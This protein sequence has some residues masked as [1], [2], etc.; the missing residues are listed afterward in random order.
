MSSGNNTYRYDV[1]LS[2][3]GEDR[4]YV[5][6]L[7]DSLRSKGIRVFYDEYARVELWG[8]D[9]YSHLDDIYQNLAR[10]CVIFLSKH[11]AQRVWTDHERRS[12]QARALREHAEYILPTRF[13][14]TIVPGI[15]ETVG[16][17][18]LRTT[19]P[20]ELCRLIVEKIGPRP[21][22]EY[23]PPV[24]DRLYKR[25]GAKGN[26]QKHAVSVVSRQF[27][28][29][30]QRMSTV[31]RRLLY[32][33]FQHCCPAELP[34]KVHIDLDLLRRIEGMSVA[35]IKRILAGIS[36]LGFECN[37][38]DGH[39]EDRSIGEPQPILVLEWHWRSISMGGNYTEIAHEIVDCATEGYCEEHGQDAL[40]RLDFCQL[41][42][43]TTELDQHS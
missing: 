15:R 9:L 21:R 27:F 41:A 16:Y 11:Y 38:R 19:P 12:A 33:I 8:R 18:D 35:K 37:V 36:S 25:V 30:L 10:Y 2:F 22:I 34:E 43:Y 23:F 7:A 24:P 13:D 1:C 14:D 4:Q 5:R 26:R 40:L 6:A 39:D 29:T 20:E 42:T 31:E 32:D 17:I 28:E 3:A